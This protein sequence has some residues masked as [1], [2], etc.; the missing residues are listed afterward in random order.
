MISSRTLERRC[1]LILAHAT[2]FARAVAARTVER[3]PLS[4]WMIL[5]P[6]VFLHYMHRA[7]K[8]K[9][10]V[11]LFS[12]ELVRTHRLA[13]EVARD[14]AAGG[15]TEPPERVPSAPGSELTAAGREIRNA[16]IR[17]VQLLSRHYRRLLAASGEDYAGLVKNAYGDPAGYRGFLAGLEAAEQELMAA[18]RRAEPQSPAVDEILGRMQAVLRKLR[19]DEVELLFSTRR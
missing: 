19:M 8:Y 5:I 11:E 4:V 10:A 2:Q 6:I 3:P 18:V 12:A 15:T 13:L 17:Q 16:E 7:Q 9:A 1:E 14:M